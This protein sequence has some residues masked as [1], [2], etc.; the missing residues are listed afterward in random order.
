MWGGRDQ[1]QASSRVH[2][3]KDP[4]VCGSANDKS[5]GR[6]GSWPD[7][8]HGAA[9]VDL[10]AAYHTYAV[11]W[12]DTHVVFS[13]DGKPIGRVDKPPV[14]VPSTPFYLIMN[15]AICGKAYCQGPW[16][17]FPQSA[18]SR[19]EVDWVR[20]YRWAADA[21]EASLDTPAAG[22]GS[23]TTDLSQRLSTTTRLPALPG[24]GGL[25]GFPAAV[26]GN[27]SAVPNETSVSNRT[28]IGG[29]RVAD[30]RTLAPA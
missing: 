18:D 26:L 29:R 22:V 15:V 19:M 14:R 24:L 3:T 2:W 1:S 17:V 8:Q 12:S 7:V 27:A 6:A 28:R 10:S 30:A 20:A 11:E 23:S 5:P 9:P 21:D 13:V 4:S 25:G 16:G